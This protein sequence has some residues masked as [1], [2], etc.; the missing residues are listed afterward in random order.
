MIVVQPAAGGVRRI[1]PPRLERDRAAGPAE[2]GARGRPRVAIC[3]IAHLCA[4]RRPSGERLQ[5][6]RGEPALLAADQLGGICAGHPG[7]HQPRARHANDSGGVLCRLGRG[8]ERERGDT[9]EPV[10]GGAFRVED[11]RDVAVVGRS[12]R[13]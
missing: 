4:R 3:R 8:R 5:L 1:G 6:A 13:R 11:R 9:A 10:A 2:P 7:R 12:R